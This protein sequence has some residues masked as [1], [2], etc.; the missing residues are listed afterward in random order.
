MALTIL[1]A[2]EDA[3]LSHAL[4]DWKV[5]AS[6]S[7]PRSL[8]RGRKGVFDEAQ[9]SSV[10]E[11]L[12]ARFFTETSEG[13]AIRKEVRSRVVFRRLNIAQPPFPMTGPLDAI[14]CQEALLPLLPGV[15]GRVI[16]A[17]KS[18]LAQDGLFRAG[19][20]EDSP[21]EMDSAEDELWQEVASN[22]SRR[23]GNC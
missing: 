6:D 23:Q 2:I 5:L 3:R 4:V 8:D 13:S 9:L 15:R 1:Q 14:F 18:L 20:L 21:I 11:D 19:D 22:L 12:L 10:S 17:A 16:A 7:S